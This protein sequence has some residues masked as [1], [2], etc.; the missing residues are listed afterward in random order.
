M[1]KNPRVPVDVVAKTD[2]FTKGIKGATAVAA[3]AM[4]AFAATSVAAVAGITKATI[5]L[6]AQLN[7]LAKNAKQVGTSVEDF[8]KVT[9]AI[10]LMTG[11]S[12]DATTAIQ[13]LQRNM[14]DARDG[15]GEAAESLAKLGVSLSD[16]DP[17]DHAGNLAILADGFTNLR[18]PAERSQVAMD[19][20]GRAGKALVPALSEG[21]EAVREATE[22]IA[23]A[24]LVSAEAAFQ[25]EVLQ[26][27]IFEAGRTFL[28]LKTDALAPLMPVIT[29]V[30]N[31]LS[32]VAQEFRDTGALKAWGE[33]AERT[34]IEVALPAIAVLGSEAE[35]AMS[36][37]AVS[38]GLAEVATLRLKVA[39]LAV[40]GRIAKAEAMTSQLGAAQ[41]E[42]DGLTADFILTQDTSIG[43]WEALT[44][45][46]R[47][48][49]KAQS[50]AANAPPVDGPSGAPSPGGEADPEGANRADERQA[51]LERIAE[52]ERKA[53]AEIWDIR[54]ELHQEILRQNDEEAERIE[55]LQQKRL[56][57]LATGLAAA[58]STFGAV[59]D[60]HGTLTDIQIG[61]LE[62][63]SKAQKKALKEQWE[64]QSAL[65]IINAA[66]AIPLA[67][68]Q[69][70]A[71]TPGPVGIA[72]GVVAGG[73]ATANL[74]VV[75]AKAAAGPSFHMGGD[76][77]RASTSPDEVNATLLRGERVQSR[78]EVRQGRSAAPSVTVLQ[79]G[80]RTVDAFIGEALRTGQGTTYDSIR[81]MQ[82]QRVGRHNPHL[83]R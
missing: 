60:L 46:I 48:A 2:K 63:G 35:K 34:F 81:G 10:G 6:S 42:L 74:A 3:G 25:A 20:F 64:A 61:N 38:F 73:I 16:L 67:I 31:A 12:A 39:F 9:G 83:R 78:A 75:I 28:A 59:A 8:Q 5:N 57:A 1:P 33:E 69:Q 22:R 40:T 71:G 19:I 36:G 30:V 65:A 49:I 4:A 79:V 45:R 44:A 80:S 66:I 70:L 14:A 52:S 77:G 62:E 72:L 11:G 58:S 13:T 41:A 32:E 55:N 27:A 18:D 15:T 50:D 21:G 47:D 23:A 26:D 7:T 53:A 82:A 68:S 54:W 29:G 37:M 17:Q 24:G 76:V 51:H 56:R 43:R